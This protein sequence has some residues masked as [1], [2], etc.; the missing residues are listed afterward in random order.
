MAQ[1]TLGRNNTRA[2]FLLFCREEQEATFLLIEKWKR[3][4][5]NT[6]RGSEPRLLTGEF[7]RESTREK[8]GEGERSKKGEDTSATAAKQPAGGILRRPEK[9]KEM[10]TGLVFF[11]F[12]FPID[13]TFSTVERLSLKDA[14]IGCRAH[15][16]ENGYLS[17]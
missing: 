16:L 11:F 14:F 12:S 6:T 9:K 8:S 15:I 4:W 13:E 1:H 10:A 2:K 7:P 5:R 3:R 17:D